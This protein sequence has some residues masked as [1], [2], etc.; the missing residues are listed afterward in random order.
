MQYSEHDVV[1]LISASAECQM[2]LGSIGT[3]VHVFSSQ[4]EAYLVEFSDN[5]G[6]EI[7]TCVLIPTQIELVWSTRDIETGQE[8]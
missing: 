3:I 8:E 6:R 1:K 5:A 7:E 2:P 4:V